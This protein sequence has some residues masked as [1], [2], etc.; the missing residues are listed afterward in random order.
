MGRD[1]SP[2]VKTGEIPTVLA[3][4]VDG[5]PETDRFAAEMILSGATEFRRDHQL[6][7]AIGAAQGKTPEQIDDFFRFAATL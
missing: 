3:V 2:A 1:R 4:M 7:A 6:T 5:L